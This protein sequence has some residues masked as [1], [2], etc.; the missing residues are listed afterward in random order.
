MTGRANPGGQHTLLAASSQSWPRLSHSLQSCAATPNRHK[1]K[2]FCLVSQNRGISLRW[3][4]FFFFFDFFFPQGLPPSLPSPLP[5]CHVSRR[6]AQADMGTRRRPRGSA[7]WHRA[8]AGTARSH[9]RRARS[10][11]KDAPRRH[12]LPAG[13]LRAWRRVRACRLRARTLKQMDLPWRV[14]RSL[15]GCELPV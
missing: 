3:F 4:S 11:G 13:C 1:N 10:G 9:E 14:A 12:Q 15:E 8:G 2:R 7:A 6:R 5:P